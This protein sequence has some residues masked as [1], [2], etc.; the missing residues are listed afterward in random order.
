M[1]NQL[2][3]RVAYRTEQSV[4]EN[5]SSSPSAGKPEK[6]MAV[7]EDYARAKGISIAR[8]PFQPVSRAELCQVHSPGYVNQVLDLK[9]PNGFG[10]FSPEVAQALPYVSGSMVAATLDSIANKG[11]C[12]S[13]TSGAHHAGYDFG[14][15]FCTFN[16]LA[17]AALRAHQVT[18]G[19]V[20][21]IDCDAHFGNGTKDII[22]KLGLDFIQHYTFGG[23]KSQAD[24]DYITK[25]L[26]QVLE[27]FKDCK[28]II[29]NA[30]ADPHIDDPLGGILT[31]EQLEDRDRV[32]LS[33][34]K[35]RSI[36]ISISLAGGYQEPL[37]KVLDIHL[38]TLK[39]VHKLL[40]GKNE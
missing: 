13:P 22:K 30:G 2:E 24:P 39:V 38:N 8:V 6:V 16:F 29:Y 19:R 34:C 18:Q 10:N 35:S 32:I 7:W 4:A 11:F 15:G 28:A 26:P 25:R 12:F 5:I 36:P 3:I 9:V 23:D 33:F 31:T 17:L 20:G 21:I 14:M 1:S 27:N 37:D 40:R